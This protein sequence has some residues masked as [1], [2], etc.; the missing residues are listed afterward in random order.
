VLP[1][2]PAITRRPFTT[3]G[4]LADAL[5]GELSQGRFDAV[6]HLAAVS[7][8]D[9]DHVDVDGRSVPVDPSGKLDS[10]D[11]MAI[12]LKRNPKLLPQLKA[13][14]GDDL[15]VVG[16]KLT[17][18]AAEDERRAA[19]AAVSPGTDLVVHNDASEIADGGHPAAIYRRDTIVATAATNAELAA[20]LEREVS[21]QLA[22]A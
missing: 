21:R 11:S 18:G 19:V 7:D 12:H 10:G 8:Y 22:G 17:S 13:L 14:G 2:D 20:V 3:F 1:A 9:I 5:A 16:F 6:V 15:V 4:D